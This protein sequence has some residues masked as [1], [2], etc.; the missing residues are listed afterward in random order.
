MYTPLDSDFQYVEKTRLFEHPKGRNFAWHF[1]EF[2]AF[3]PGKCRSFPGCGARCSRP[4]WT[5][6]T[7]ATSGSPLASASSTPRVISSSDNSE[8]TCPETST[9]VAGSDP[10]NVEDTPV[11]PLILASGLDTCGRSNR[12]F[13][14]RW[15]HRFCPILVGHSGKDG[16]LG[17][18][19]GQ[20]LVR[21][22]PIRLDERR[23]QRR[24]RRPNDAADVLGDLHVAHGRRYFVVA[25]AALDLRHVDIRLTSIVIVEAAT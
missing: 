24:E 19:L 8:F 21:A 7:R 13:D 2:Y 3:P 17:Q 20:S 25:G 23:R 9:I 11:S 1:S 10:A 14:S 16:H 18:S 5:P 22:V 4:N 6:S 12:A 15:G